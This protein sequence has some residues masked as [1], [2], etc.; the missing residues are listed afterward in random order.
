MVREHSLRVPVRAAS[1]PKAVLILKDHVSIV[2]AGRHRISA[3]LSAPTRTPACHGAFG[4]CSQC[5]CCVASYA[6]SSTAVCSPHGSVRRRRSPSIAVEA[7]RSPWLD[8]KGK[9]CEREQRRTLSSSA[10][11]H[12]HSTSLPAASILPNAFPEPRHSLGRHSLRRVPT[13]VLAVGDVDG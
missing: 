2:H 4:S 11:P 1:P 8:T 9:R 7:F 10:S 6:A 5:S 12:P 13:C 3:M